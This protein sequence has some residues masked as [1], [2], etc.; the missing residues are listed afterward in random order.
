ML[1][2]LRKPPLLNPGDFH[3]ITERK[4]NEITNKAEYVNV[5][6][7]LLCS[8][9]GLNCIKLGFKSTDNVP[10]ECTGEAKLPTISP[11]FACTLCSTSFML[12]NGELTETGE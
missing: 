5:G 2:N 8:H 3:Y 4:R 12:E 11:N 9:C 1:L 7:V 10:Y 6:M